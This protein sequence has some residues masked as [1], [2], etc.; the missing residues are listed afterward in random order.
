VAVTSVV[1]TDIVP[2]GT[3][4][5][6]VGEA[7]RVAGNQVQWRI[8]TLPP[9]ARRTVQI[10]LQ[11]QQ[12]GEIVNRATAVADFNLTA[13]AEARTLFEGATGL[14][15]DIE[16]KDNPIEVGGQTAYIV[17]V[18]NQGNAPATGIRIAVK[19]PEE[20][21]YLSA[22]APIEPQIQ[23]QQISFAPLPILQPQ[24]ETRYVIHVRVQRNGEKA[25]KCQAEL[26]ADQLGDRPVI[27]EQLTTIYPDSAPLRPVPKGN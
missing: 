22:Q 14:T 9:G 2:A 15:F 12:A 26:R 20:M 18:L 24:V 16:V 7:G 25:V 21:Q 11:A 19:L 5:V 23:G 3:S 6:S 4:V 1:V 10:A 27:R 17:T 8:G 13:E